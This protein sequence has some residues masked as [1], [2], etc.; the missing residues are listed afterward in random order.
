MSHFTR[1]QMIQALG[2]GLGVLGLTPLLNAST[3][4]PAP[5]FAPRA[6]RVIQ[7]FMNGGPFQGDLFDPK[8]AI[9]RYAGQRP[10][11]VELR[12]ENQTGGLM[13]VPFRYRKHGQSGLE[14]SELL[15][16]L[17]NH[18]DELCVV[19]S[20]YTDNPNHGPAL[21]LMN[22]GSMTP[23]RPSLGAWLSYGLGTENANLPAHVVLCPG[24]PVRFAELWSAG[25]LPG[26]HQGSYVNPTL[27]DTTQMIPFLG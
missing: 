10:A 5:H 2:G 8:P 19:R 11:A 1:R 18:A 23:T 4:A 13:P 17:A 21:Y 27:G 22:N 12:T 14:I 25:F 26:E 15:P 24:R 7:L 16:R 9:N 6:R 20:L 3:A